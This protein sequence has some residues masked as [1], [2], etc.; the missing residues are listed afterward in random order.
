MGENPRPAH[1]ASTAEPPVA[2]TIPQEDRA[3]TIPR[4]VHRVA[5]AG[6]A[7]SLEGRCGE[8]RHD[9]RRSAQDKRAQ[10]RP[11]PHTQA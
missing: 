4:Q 8:R 2:S 3:R 7:S 11:A 1:H 10:S 5:R 9:R 6:D